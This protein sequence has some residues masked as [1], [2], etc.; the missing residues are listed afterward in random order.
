MSQ[1]KIASLLGVTQPAVK[2]Y[3]EE[4]ERLYKKKLISMGIQ[5]KEIDDLL[6]SLSEILTREDVKDA[7]SF[8]TTRSL[9][10]LSGL[11]FC[12]FHRSIDKDIPIDCNICS[13]FYKENDESLLYSALGMLQNPLISS[14]IPQVLSNI[15]FARRGASNC[16]DVLAIPGRIANVRGIPMAASRPQWGGS[17]HLSKVILKVMGLCSDIRSV[18]DIK[19][20][21]S[22][23]SAVERSGLKHSRIGPQDFADDEA[24][25][26]AIK[27]VF[28]CSTDVVFHMGGKGLEPVSYIFGKDP[29]EVAEKVV[30][31]AKFYA[32]N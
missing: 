17:K 25:A 3:L 1:T 20:D 5:E 10:F 16:N 11:R 8:V 21:I 18:M 32:S 12:K 22:V 15:A 23:E 29:L 13:S 9:I 19:Y 26:D 24:I 14:L 31:I 28:D 6:Y 2:Q 7:M 30:K 27:S 4:D